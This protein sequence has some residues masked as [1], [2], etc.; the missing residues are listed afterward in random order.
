VVVQTTVS[1]AERIERELEQADRT[2]QYRQAAPAQRVTFDQP[3]APQPVAQSAPRIVASQP[4]PM[5]MQPAMAAAG[6]IAMPMPKTTVVN[7]SK[8]S[9][10]LRD[11][12]DRVL[13]NPT[14]K[15][16]INGVKSGAN[17][18][19]NHPRVK[20]IQAKIPDNI[21]D[22]KVRP[23][24]AL[25]Y[26]VVAICLIVAGFLAYDTWQTNQQIQSVFG[27]EPA[28]AI[29]APAVAVAE[30]S[31]G[32]GKAYPNYAVAADMPRVL[33]LPT[34]GMSAM[35]LQVGLTASNQ[36]STPDSMWDAGW[37]NGSAMPGQTGASFIT[38]HY[39]VGGGGGVFDNLGALND[40][41][42]VRVE[43]G[44]GTTVN[45]A[46]YYKETIPV[47]QVD[48]SAVL[49]SAGEGGEGLNLL[50]CAGQFTR[51]GFSHRTI[52]YTKR[53]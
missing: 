24:E 33:Y 14:V 35:V 18:V 51:Y 40:G 5:A 6:G 12:R 39:N 21:K 27:P 46:V 45:Y 50:T 26:G 52:V 25:R 20:Q 48:M 53:V 43:L 22:I 30:N 13:N 37:Y 4:V 36:V 42:T 23:G 28:A 41:D 3:T 31:G 29:E 15:K 10:K 17:K 32:D 8:V 1:Q 38:G 19:K 2:V 49:M 44:D 34:I 11:G 16:T 47:D 7:F 9:Q